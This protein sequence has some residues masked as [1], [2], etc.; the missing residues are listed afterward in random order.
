MMVTMMVMVTISM[1]MIGMV[2]VHDVEGTNS[3]PDRHY[4]DGDH[5]DERHNIDGGDRNCHCAL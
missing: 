3:C 5:D 4:H 1:V 2:K